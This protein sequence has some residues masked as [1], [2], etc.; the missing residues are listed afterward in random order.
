MERLRTEL[1]RILEDW[2]NEERGNR[3]TSNN[4]QGL[5]TK[6]G[7]VFDSYEETKKQE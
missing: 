1:K 4:V 2:Y 3:V 6:I 7:V 5:A